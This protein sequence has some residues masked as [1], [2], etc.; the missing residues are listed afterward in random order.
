MLSLDQIRLE[1]AQL[2]GELAHLPSSEFP[3]V[4]ALVSVRLAA[5]KRSE[6]AWLASAR[7]QAINCQPP[8]PSWVEHQRQER[9]TTMKNAIPPLRGELARTPEWDWQK[10][11]QLEGAIAE[12]ERKV[13]ELEAQPV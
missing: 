12:Y 1:S 3:T 8:H 6:E 2:A 11:Q 7:A 10:R 4:H 13:E 9:I 5:L